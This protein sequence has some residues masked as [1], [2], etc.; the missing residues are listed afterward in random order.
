MEITYNAAVN[1]LQGVLALACVENQYLACVRT[2]MRDVDLNVVESVR[3]DT[4]KTHS[5]LLSLYDLQSK[6][7]AHVDQFLGGS[8][9]A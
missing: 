7:K 8:L 9:S 6:V 2:Y 5:D 1:H 4:I 3:A